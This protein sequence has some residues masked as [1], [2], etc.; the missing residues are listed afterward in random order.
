M[1]V[2]SYAKVSFLEAYITAQK[3]DIVC[4]SKTYFDLSTAYDDGN[5]KIAGY[6]LIWF[7]HPSNKKQGCSK[8]FE[9]SL[10]TGMY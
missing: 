7:D 3:F 5:L 9:F 1:T 2:H 4:I 6:S 10:F 8:S